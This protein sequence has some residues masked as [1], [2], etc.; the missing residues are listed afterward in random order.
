MAQRN[1]AIVSP[2]DQ[3]HESAL[4]ARAEPASSTRPTV[5]GFRAAEAEAEHA[6]ESEQ[7]DAPPGW[8]DPFEDLS[9]TTTAPVAPPSDSSA[10]TQEVADAPVAVEELGT[11]NPKKRKRTYR[12]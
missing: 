9:I 3:H 1:V 10:T 7:G 8:A 6:E 2:D 12:W 11:R 4:P 5:P